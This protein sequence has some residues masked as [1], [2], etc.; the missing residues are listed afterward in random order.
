MGGGV[1]QGI[2]YDDIKKILL[3]IPP[4]EEQQAIVDYLD[5]KN[6]EIDTLITVRQSKID[7]LKEYK[8]SIIYEYIT[9]K[10]EVPYG[11]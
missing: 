2:N 3:V 6:K 9:G 10:K 1:R 8:K 5:T 4:V 11:E 7:A